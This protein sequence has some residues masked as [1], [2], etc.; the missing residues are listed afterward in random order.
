M[1]NLVPGRRLAHIGLVIG[2]GLLAGCG[3]SPKP[4]DAPSPAPETA[5]VKTAAQ[6]LEGLHISTLDPSTMNDAEIRRVVESSRHC[7]F[8]YTS[9]GKPVVVAGVDQNG[10]PVT[11]VIKLSGG[12]IAL[13]PDSGAAG[14]GSGGFALAADP[15]HVRL[16]LDP[17][18]AASAKSGKDQVEA[19]MIFEV[20]QQLKVGYSGYLDCKAPTAS[21]N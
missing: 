3:Q 11:G 12:I 21:T 20:G 10:N 1:S 13:Q 7:T 16:Q 19:D 18:A 8:R 17:Q 14:K 6:A 9:T 2:V 15:V 5:R 4:D